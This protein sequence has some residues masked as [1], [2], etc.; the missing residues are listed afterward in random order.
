MAV[1]LWTHAYRIPDLVSVKNHSH[2]KIGQHHNNN[3][4]IDNEVD[5]RKSL[6]DRRGCR[7][8]GVI[9]SLAIQEPSIPDEGR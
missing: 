8:I 5:G 6:F 9:L 2:E 1:S 4:D 3:S 7:S